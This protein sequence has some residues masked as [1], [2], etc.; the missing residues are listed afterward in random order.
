MLWSQSHSRHAVAAVQRRERIPDRRGRHP[1]SVHAHDRRGGSAVNV[2]AE[3]L[4]IDGRERGYQ[5][6]SDAI[7]EDI[8]WVR[9]GRG[10]TRGV[11]RLDE[12]WYESICAVLR[13]VFTAV[14]V[15]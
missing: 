10:R 2:F 1:P 11:E 6:I 9:L 4:L 5:C 7:L 13:G 8:L 14:P 3:E 15:E 12:G